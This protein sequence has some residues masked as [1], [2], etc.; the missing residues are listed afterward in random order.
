[1]RRICQVFRAAEAIE[2]S[3]KTRGTR[4]LK[5]LI[6]RQIRPVRKQLGGW[7]RS[8]RVQSTECKWQEPLV[9]QELYQTGIDCFFDAYF[10]RL[11]SSAPAS[12]RRIHK[13]SDQNA[14][15]AASQPYLRP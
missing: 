5:H 10:V 8:Q 3:D 1:M 11:Q 2:G 4:M 14:N 12:K 13:L 6:L 9:K 7:F 15:R